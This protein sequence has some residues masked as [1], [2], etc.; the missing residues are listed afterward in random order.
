[1]FDRGNTV[2]S[3][4]MQALRMSKEYVSP[5]SEQVQDCAKILKTVSSLFCSL[6]RCR[7]AGSYLGWSSYKNEKSFII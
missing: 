6:L 5:E 1:M 3:K 4:A 7:K 2:A